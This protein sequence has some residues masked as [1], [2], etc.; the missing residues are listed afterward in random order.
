MNTMSASAW[1]WSLVTFCGC[2][3][4]WMIGTFGLNLFNGLMAALV[5]FIITAFGRLAIAGGK[6]E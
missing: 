5:I 6:G 4:S 1:R 2:W 3:M